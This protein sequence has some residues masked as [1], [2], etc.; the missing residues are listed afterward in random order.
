MLT[1][2]SPV[3]CKGFP[4]DTALITR[5]LRLSAA[6]PLIPAAGF[7][8]REPPVC[9]ERIIFTAHFTLE[10]P[11]EQNLSEWPL[12][13]SPGSGEGSVHDT[14]QLRQPRVGWTFQSYF[15]SVVF[16]GAQHKPEIRYTGTRC[17][18][19]MGNTTFRIPSYFLTHVKSH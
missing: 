18:V 6:P 8:A 17:M 14:P 7:S 11:H 2:I 10:V 12:P 19:A 16:P 9:R 3:P 5:T 13:A 15:D 4:A 1:L